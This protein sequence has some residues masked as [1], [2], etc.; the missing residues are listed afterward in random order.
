VVGK[1]VQGEHAGEGNSQNMFVVHMSH[2][3]GVRKRP[4]I[5]FGRET[6]SAVIVVMRRAA[7]CQ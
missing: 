4:A 6:V 7:F 3:P 2:V 5:S 1:C